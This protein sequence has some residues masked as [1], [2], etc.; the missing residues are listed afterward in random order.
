MATRCGFCDLPLRGAAALADER[1][2]FAGARRAVF[3]LLRAVDL[4]ASFFL[5]AERAR[6]IKKSPCRLLLVG[7][8]LLRRAAPV[9][10]L[11]TVRFGN[12]TRDNQVRRA[13]STRPPGF[14]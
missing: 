12:A 13:A 4:R 8:S 3:A 9:R 14:L 1:A 2:D 6:A 5:A 11:L 7:A 10:L